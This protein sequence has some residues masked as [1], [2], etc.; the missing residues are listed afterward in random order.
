MI[1]EEVC[2][3]SMKEAII[4]KYKDTDKLNVMNKTILAGYSPDQ[5]LCIARHNPPELPVD[6][7]HSKMPYKGDSGSSLV[8]NL[9]DPGRA[10]TV[11]VTSAGIPATL[12]VAI[13]TR[14]AHY[15]D[16]ISQVIQND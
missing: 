11:G 6:K 2:M 9:G 14:V 3:D 4:L 13:M 1:D 15:I 5:H 16:W 10:H 8:A 7:T 12:P